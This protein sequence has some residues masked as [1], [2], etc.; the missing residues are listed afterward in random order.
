MINK[1]TQ[2]VSLQARLAK[3][4]YGSLVYGFA[5]EGG[6]AGKSDYVNRGADEKKEV[7]S[8]FFT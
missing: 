1:L 6:S 5:E 2:I 3:N 4:M 7:K 8:L